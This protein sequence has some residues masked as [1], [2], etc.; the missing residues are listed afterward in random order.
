MKK[1][2]AW[3]II[4]SLASACAPAAVLAESVFD[5]S[6]ARGLRPVLD[7][8]TRASGFGASAA[9]ANEAPGTGGESSNGISPLKAAA[10]SLLLPGLG[11]RRLGHTLRSKIYFGLEGISWLSIGSFLW[12]GYSREQSYRDYAVVYADVTG[13]DHSDEFYKRIEEYMSNDGP[14]GY[15]EAMRRDARDLYY[16]NVE[17]M[18]AYYRASRMTGDE[19]W[20]WRTTDAFGRFGTLRNGSRF[21][22]RVALYS[23]IAAAALRVVSAADAARLARKDAQAGKTQHA[24][25]IGLA[26]KTR[27]IALY[28]QRS[29]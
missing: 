8:G 16:P 26:Q 3:I 25:S 27:G 13:T 18:E 15:N 20:R 29:F 24:V 7:L 12:V 1:I 17:A 23:A 28:V 22:Y 9:I 4:C 14:G 11:A 5:A 10:S 21:A 19:S 2:V 6:G